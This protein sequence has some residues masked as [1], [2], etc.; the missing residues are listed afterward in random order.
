MR[1][2]SLVI[3]VFLIAVM[4]VVPTTRSWLNKIGESLHNAF[5]NEEVIE[6]NAS[7]ENSN[8]LINQLG[9]SE[10]GL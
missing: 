3:I 2:K 6:D 7:D 4:F 1:F 9:N 8:T 10:G 5:V